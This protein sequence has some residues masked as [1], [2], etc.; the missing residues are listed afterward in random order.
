[1]SNIKT[2]LDFNTLILNFLFQIKK[3]SFYPATFEFQ[4][5]FVSKFQSKA[6]VVRVKKFS[7][8]KVYHKKAK[9]QF[10]I[11]LHPEKKKG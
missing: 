8:E 7:F 11:H 10:V 4:K 2:S 5:L 9:L 3:F 6:K 1:M